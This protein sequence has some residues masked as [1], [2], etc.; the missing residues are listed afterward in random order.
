MTRSDNVFSCCK[1]CKQY[2]SFRNKICQLSVVYTVINVIM[3][4]HAYAWTA[5]IIRRAFLLFFE[6]NRLGIFSGVAT[7]EALG[8]VPTL[9]FQIREPTI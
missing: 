1:K 4:A 8:H 5:I 7:Y 2:E 6:H 9:D 3:A